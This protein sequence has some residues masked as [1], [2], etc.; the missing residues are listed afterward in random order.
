MS[1]PV[2]RTFF[3][4]MGYDIL[5]KKSS[6]LVIAAKFKFDMVNTTT[7]ANDNILTGSLKVGGMYISVI[8]VYGLQET[9]S[10]DSRV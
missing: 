1:S 5:L 8:A 10:A 9:D 6:G 2:I 3:K 4:S 7:T